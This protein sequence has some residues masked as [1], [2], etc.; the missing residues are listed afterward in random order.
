MGKGLYEVR[1]NLSSNRIARLFFCID[2]EE[3]VVLHGFIK[4]KTQ[5]TPAADLA[6]ARA[7][8]REVEG[9]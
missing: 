1:S 6:L 5:K 8:Q 7:R 3:F 4:K 2:R 9:S